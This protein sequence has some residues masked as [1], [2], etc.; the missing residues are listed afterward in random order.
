[1][2]Q[3][4]VVIGV[5]WGDEGKGKIV[6]TYS[7]WADAVARFQGG[8]NAG[9][10]LVVNGKQTILHLI[11]SGVL[12]PHTQCLIGSGVVVD[13]EAFL[14]E[15]ATLKAAGQADLEKRVLLSDRCHLILEYHKALDAAREGHKGGLGTTKRGIGPAYEDR[16]SRRGLRVVDLLNPEVFIT[17]VKE[18]L[19]EKNVL[20]KH[21]YGAPEID[22][23]ETIEKYRELAEAI[24]PFV[25]DVA[26]VI[27]DHIQSG[28]KILYE[29]AQGIL[30][31]VDYGTYPFVTSS[32]TLPS[33]CALGL[34]ARKPKDTVF[35]GVMKA[36]T[37]RVGEG[38]FPTELKDALGEKLRESGSEFG[39]TTGRPRR[40]G[41]LDLIAVRYAIR[42]S[43]IRHLTMT[44]AD[45]LSGMETLKVCVGYRYKGK[46]LETFPA[47]TS[48]LWEVEPVYETVPGWKEDL[49]QIQSEKA[50]PS[51]LRDYIAFIEKFTGAKVGS[52]STG[53]GREQVI[54]IERPF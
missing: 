50:M 31:D 29:G 49:K 6:D 16:A 2:P 37:T 15:I 28:N 13:P 5:Q 48:V 23:K 33:Q 14:K 41:W 40:C 27:D 8:N 26:A 51:G 17:K 52:V 44:K 22:M 43:G 32:H 38:P 47:D 25:H 24:R 35:V 9:H 11:P 10:T 7:E 46:T 3:A 4:V 30:L 45:V 20:L 39:A 34:G 19:A 12:H 21:L 42:V 18:N 1:M 53:P 54:E 36:Y